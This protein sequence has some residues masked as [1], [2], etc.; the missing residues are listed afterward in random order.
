L[1]QPE[2]AGAKSVFARH[3]QAAQSRAAPPQPVPVDPGALVSG[4]KLSLSEGRSEL[5]LRLRP[6][7]LGRAIVSL[8]YLEDGLRLEFQLERP[9]ARQAIEA[10]SAKLKE[11]LA[12]AGFQTVSIEVRIP[13]PDGERPDLHDDDEDRRQSSR[14]QD[15]N[16]PDSEHRQQQNRPP[17]MFGYNT[18]DIAA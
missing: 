7:V 18:F 11:A 3:H 12:A 5:V 4:I 17:L 15:D 2:A 14:D 1:H 13:D 6:E 10:E 8:R 9:E 16:N